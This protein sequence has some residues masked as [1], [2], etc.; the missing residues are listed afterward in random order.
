[1]STSKSH[2]ERGTAGAG[3]TWTLPAG[4]ATQSSAHLRWL[5]AARVGVAVLWVLSLLLLAAGISTALFR[6][7]ASVNAAVLRELGLSMG[8]WAVYKVTFDSLVTLG[9]L[10]LV[11]I[12]IWRRSDDWMA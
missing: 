1:M 3:S 10:A 8:F 2:R 6:E 9:Y 5:A 4:D 12:L 11:P 7:Q